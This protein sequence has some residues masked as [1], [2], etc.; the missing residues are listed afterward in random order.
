METTQRMTETEIREREGFLHYVAREGRWF[1][2]WTM[3]ASIIA[4]IVCMVSPGF[5]F[6]AVV[7]ALVLLVAYV[8]L[9]LTN[10]VERRSDTAAHD[11]LEQAETAVASDV[12][13][14][15]AED[16]QVHPKHAHIIRRESKTGIAI[17]AAIM[18][19]ALLIASVVLDLRVVAIGA[20][21]VFAYMLLVAAPLWLGW[22]ED[23]IEVQGDRMSATEESAT[24]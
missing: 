5:F 20:F 14:N 16:G 11:M 21:V 23:D 19:A 2:R 22:I 12:V 17:V 6:V 9:L 10:E 24:R 7:P 8:L 15:H 1:L 3:I 4:I 13:E 18:V